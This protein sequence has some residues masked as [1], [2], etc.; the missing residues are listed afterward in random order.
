MT[1]HQRFARAYARAAPEMDRRGAAAHRAA[2]LAGLTGSVLEIGAGIGSNFTHYPGGVGFVLAVEPDSHLRGLADRAAAVAGRT[3]AGRSIEVVAGRAENLPARSGTFD[4]AVCS[5]VLCSVADQAVALAEI[6]R[7]LRP[8]GRL[9]FY[10]HV[11]SAHRL[12]ALAEDLITPLYRRM[13]GDCH[14]NRDTAAAIAAA[15]FRI[16]QLDR[17]GF[18]PLPAAPRTAHL[19]GT[20]R[21]AGIPG[22][23][24]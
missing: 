3:G 11:R 22:G 24:G 17:F 8:G 21:S 2:M 12:L 1:E 15:G 19:L 13:A 14:P 10:E 20:A 6:R 18:A 7:V 16:E 4:A 23:S 9:V 5:L